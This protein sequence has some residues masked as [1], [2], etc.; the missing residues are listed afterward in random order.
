MGRASSERNNEG[1]QALT[2]F[3]TYDPG[4]TT[5]FEGDPSTWFDDSSGTPLEN[6]NVSI[7]LSEDLTPNDL[8]TGRLLGGLVGSDCLPFRASGRLRRIRCLAWG[9]TSAPTRAG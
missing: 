5:F 7:V 4:F 6:P 8:G 1:E 2:F 9:L 3:E